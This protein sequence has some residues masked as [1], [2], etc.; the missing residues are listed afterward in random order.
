MDDLTKRQQRAIRKRIYVKQSSEPEKEEE[1]VQDTNSGRFSIKAVSFKPQSSKKE[2][3]ISNFSTRESVDF[4]AF[5]KYAAT[6]SSIALFVGFIY[7]IL[8][9]PHA[10]KSKA[11]NNGF[12]KKYFSIFQSP[13]QSA[14]QDVDLKIIE[15]TVTEPLEEIKPKLPPKKK[16]DKEILKAQENLSE[17]RETSNSEKIAILTGNKTGWSASFQ[18]SSSLKTTEDRSLVMLPAWMINAPDEERCFGE[19]FRNCLPQNIMK[20]NKRICIKTQFPD[21]G[22]EISEVLGYFGSTNLTGVKTLSFDEYT[23]DRQQIKKLGIVHG[24]S[25]KI[26]NCPS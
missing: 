1:E 26:T 25:W 21:G 6:V 19:G 16:I 20:Q 24:I 15:L 18:S 12:D 14:I 7:W 8:F 9:T 17:I 22:T 23:A 4:N 11:I 3:R 5:F 13:I 2:E 10:P